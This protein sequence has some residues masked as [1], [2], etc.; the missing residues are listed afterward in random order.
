[1]HYEN[2]AFL[3]T[4]S[5]AARR[6]TSSFPLPSPSCSC[7]SL[8]LLATKFLDGLSSAHCWLVG[9]FRLSGLRAA[10][11]AAPCLFN[12]PPPKGRPEHEHAASGIQPVAA[13]HE[14]VYRRGHHAQDPKQRTRCDGDAPVGGMRHCT[15]HEPQWH[16]KVPCELA[17]ER[18]LVE[19]ELQRR[20]RN[21]EHRHDGAVHSSDR[22]GC[23]GQCRQAN[24]HRRQ[25][26]A[27]S[28]RPAPMVDG[29]R[30]LFFHLHGRRRGCLGRHIVP[31]G[32]ACSQA[33]RA[34]GHYAL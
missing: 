9:H 5:S 28:R 12:L 21:S 30:R 20:K 33:S 15:R 14:A 25:C 2:N 29:A 10:T 23:C 4:I 16:D 22:R 1:M 18:D 17:C 19:P 31:A 27:R 11:L 6:H 8:C 7:I 34:R 26:S 13:M 32:E 3:Q 24:C